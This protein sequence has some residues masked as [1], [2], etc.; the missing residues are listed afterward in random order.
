M[1]IRP[2][3]A[4]YLHCEL[5]V[6]FFGACP[7]LPLSRPSGVWYPSSSYLPLAYSLI[8]LLTSGTDDGDVD[9]IDDDDSDRSLNK[10]LTSIDPLLQ[11]SSHLAPSLSSFSFSLS[12]SFLSFSMR[13]SWFFR[14]CCCCCCFLFRRVLPCLLILTDSKVVVVVRVVSQAVA[15]PKRSRSRNAVTSAKESF[16][17]FF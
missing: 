3:W 4:I 13:E 15:E 17:D 11:Q 16:W 12:R 14:C 6:L 7:Q 5:P 2:P 9:D 8:H 1:L 10:D